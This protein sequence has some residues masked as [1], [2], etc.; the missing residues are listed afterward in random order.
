MTGPSASNSS[1]PS[2]TAESLP[3]LPPVLA[4]ALP[5]FTVPEPQDAPPLRWGIIGAGHIAGTFASD[6]PAYSSGRVVA[7]GARDRGRAEV[8]AAAHPQ[9]DGVAAPDGGVPA[10]V[11]SYEDLVSRDDVDAVYVATPH[12]IHAEHALTEGDDSLAASYIECEIGDRIFWGVGIDGSIT[13]ASLEAIVS[14]L[15]REHRARA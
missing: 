11:G 14:A 7:V 1:D 4:Q 6:V 15:N 13:R 10:A 3:P 2:R 5:T 8:F 9:P 12:A